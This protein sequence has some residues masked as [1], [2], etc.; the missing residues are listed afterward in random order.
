MRKRALAAVAV[1]TVLVAGC[2]TAPEPEAGPGP[3]PGP[4]SSPSLTSSTPASQPV[5][6]PCSGA[7]QAAVG[8]F[9]ETSPAEV[10]SFEAWLGCRVDYAIDFSARDTW[11]DIANPAYLHRAWAGKPRRLVLGVAM[12]PSEGNVSMAAGAR[13]EYDRYF[14]DLARNLIGDGQADAILRVGWE[15]NLSGSTW[16]TRD[17]SVFI[18][19]WRRIADAMSSVPGARFRFDWNP[20]NGRNPVDAAAYYPGDDVVDYVGIDAYDV[21]NAYPYPSTCDDACRLGVQQKA[22]NTTIFGG[23]RGLRFWS[24]FARQHDKPLSLPEWGLWSRPDGTG[25]GENLFYLDQMHAFIVDPANHVAYQAYFELNGSDGKHRLMT[26]FTAAGQR[27]R[28]LFN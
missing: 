19:Y 28:A 3:G 11:A 5:M 27:Y 7:G 20:N 17:S 1:M 10:A 23:S 14:A 4:S 25:G 21:A 24:D 6:R 22:W 15:F 8:V 18:T 2:T 26:T 12:L 13:G 9:R 16:F